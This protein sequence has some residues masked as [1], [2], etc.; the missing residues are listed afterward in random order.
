MFFLNKTIEATFRRLVVISIVLEVQSNT[1]TRIRS[2]RN[3]QML[4]TA[5]TITKTF[6]YA[7]LDH[8]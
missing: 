6:M 1:L 5:N 8:D 7:K 2:R 4:V 3:L